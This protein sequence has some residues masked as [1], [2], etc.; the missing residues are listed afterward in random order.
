MVKNEQRFKEILEKY[1]YY[2]P[3]TVN[4]A[5]YQMIKIEKNLQS[6]K[7]RV[8]ASGESKCIERFNDRQNGEHDLAKAFSDYLNEIHLNDTELY[9]RHGLGLNGNTVL[10]LDNI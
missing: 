3:N 8:K 1:R 9:A 2:M 5:R 7:D 10:V 4:N 6:N